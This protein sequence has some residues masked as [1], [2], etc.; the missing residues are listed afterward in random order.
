LIDVFICTCLNVFI[1]TV[2]NCPFEL[3][4]RFPFSILIAAYIV[5]FAS[6]CFDLNII[7]IIV[8][9]RDNI[10]KLRIPNAIKMFVWKA[11]C[12][13]LP[14][15]VNLKR[16]KIIENDIC[17][18]NVE[19]ARHVLWDC[20]SAQ[21]VWSDSKQVLQKSCC[22]GDNFM[23]ANQL[24][25]VGVQIQPNTSYWSA[26]PTDSL[27]ANWDASINAKEK[28]VGIGVIIRD[29]HGLV[30]AALSKTVQAVFDPSTAEAVAALH[31]PCSGIL[32]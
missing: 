25:N 18:R 12:N 21:D 23:A 22:D 1:C 27:K 13:I 16:R 31:G 4:C 17:T 7:I 5:I 3:P 14:T 15:R 19:T 32:S 28:L 8:E 6:L 29:E 20:V 9:K 2:F 30:F 11:C 24:E 10:W 26:P